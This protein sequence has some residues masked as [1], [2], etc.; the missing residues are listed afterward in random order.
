VKGPLILFTGKIIPMYAKY[1]A[2]AIE[3]MVEVK[4]QLPNVEFWIYGDGIAKDSLNEL[5]IKLHINVF[6]KG[7][8][9]YEETPKLATIADIGISAYRAE[10]IKMIEWMRMGLPVLAPITDDARIVYSNWTIADLSSM[11]IKL[12]K[13]NER[14]YKQV[15]S[16]KEVA[17]IISS[18]IEKIIN[19]N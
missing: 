2:T 7:V 6:L 15:R 16:W 19:Q 4:K 5:V 10:S 13:K 12:L 9:D 1:L 3:A 14:M 8:V 11:I 18:D 17:R